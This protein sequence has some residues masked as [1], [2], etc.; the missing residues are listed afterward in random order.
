M[1]VGGLCRDTHPSSQYLFRFAG[2][3]PIARATDTPYARGLSLW[4]GDGSTTTLPLELFSRRLIA[5]ECFKTHHQ[6]HPLVLLSSLLFAAHVELFG[7]ALNLKC[8]E[9][10]LQL[11]KD[12]G[13]WDLQ[14]SSPPIFRLLRVLLQCLNALRLACHKDYIL[15]TKFDLSQTQLEECSSPLILAE[16]CKCCLKIVASLPRNM[17]VQYGRKYMRYC[18]HFALRIPASGHAIEARMYS[19]LIQRMSYPFTSLS[20]SNI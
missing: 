15:V 19:N 4:Y 11:S 14:T 12:A 10:A 9:S 7:V 1:T 2:E 18:L 20:D 5:I 17:S 3:T 13:R 6:L 16:C 8:Y